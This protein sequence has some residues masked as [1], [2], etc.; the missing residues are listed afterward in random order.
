MP[1]AIDELPI[2]ALLGAFAEGRT[3]VHGAEELRR[4]ESDRITTVVEGLRGLGA[5]IEAA[6]DGFMMEGTGG[7]VGGHMDAAGDHR[8]AMLGA[9]A[10]LASREGVD[11][12]GFQVADVSYPGFAAD[13]EAVAG[14]RDRSG[15]GE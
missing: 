11:V 7:L 12:T 15:A 4:K 2:V 5:R 9:V 13:L 3:S 14:R 10:G 8:L 6:P 1:L